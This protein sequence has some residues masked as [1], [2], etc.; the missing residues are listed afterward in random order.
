VSVFSVSVISLLSLV[1]F[2][3]LFSVTSIAIIIIITVQS[4]GQ[5]PYSSV[6]WSVPLSLSSVLS[7][8]LIP[9][10][11]SP[12]APTPFAYPSVRPL[13][14][15]STSPPLI[16]ASHYQFGEKIKI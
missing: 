8:L 11:S 1:L 13:S 7:R 6:S 12:H 14:A 3:S 15:S 16:P 9:R 5:S 2:S 4:L 10:V